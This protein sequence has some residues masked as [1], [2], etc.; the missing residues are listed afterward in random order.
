MRFSERLGIVP[1]KLELQTDSIDDPLRHRLWS[2]VHAHY[3]HKIYGATGYNPTYSREFSAI[4][5]A[6]RFSF[7][8]VPTDEIRTNPGDEAD[9]IKRE[10]YAF[11]WFEVYDFIEY[12]A[13]FERH[14]FIAQCN[15]ILEEERSAYRFLGKQI[16]RITDKEEIKE[17]EQASSASNPK[18]IRVHIEQSIRLYSDRAFPDY[19]NAI[20]EAISAVEAAAQFITYDDKATL[21][22]ALS[23]IEESHEIHPALKKGFSNI[24]GYT[25]DAN[26]I[27]HALSE[28]REI[29]EADA[30]FMIVSCSAFTN[31]LLSLNS[32]P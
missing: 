24:Y 19:R 30:R 5:R 17:V 16:T 26:G 23:K 8:K 2:I 15:R 32:K 3:F 12:L 14:G 13:R 1:P 21:G 11:D 29:S 7:F 22:K 31:Y 10:F 18:T 28:A 25:N 6:L 20:K 9:Y 27:R 4:A